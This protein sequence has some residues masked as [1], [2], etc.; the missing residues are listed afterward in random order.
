MSARAQHVDRIRALDTDFVELMTSM[1]T[2]ASLDLRVNML[3]CTRDQALA[4]LR[5][6]DVPADPTPLCH[7]W[8]PPAR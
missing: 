8:N 1:M 2:S 6:E 3:K 7:N 5:K 4:S